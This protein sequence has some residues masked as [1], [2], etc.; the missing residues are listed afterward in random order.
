M[1]DELLVVMGRIAVGW[2]QIVHHL[3]LINL[4]LTGTTVEN[5]KQYPTRS[6]RRK[7]SDLYRELSS[8]TR[9]EIRPYLLAAHNAIDALTSDRNVIFHGLWG[10]GLDQE[11]NQWTPLSRSY[12]REQPFLLSDLVDFHERMVAGAVAVSEAFWRLTVENSPPP[13]GRNLRQLWAD[14]P[15]TE[16]SPHPPSVIAR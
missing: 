12:T 10:W 11:A 14:G 16:T 2:G 8:P 13:G 6:M 1:D 4:T 15:P 9:K 7:L 5:L 3:D